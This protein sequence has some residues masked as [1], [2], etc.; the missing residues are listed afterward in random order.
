MTGNVVLKQ[1]ISVSKSV[2]KDLQDTMLIAK[3]QGLVDKAGEL[4]VD[5]AG[6]GITLELIEAAQEWVNRY[7]TAVPQPKAWINTRKQKTAAM[8]AVFEEGDEAVRVIDALA[9]IVEY[10]VPLFY[11]DY[12]S[13]RKIVNTA[14]RTRA[15][16]LW[17]RDAA[18]G[19]PIVKAMVLLR[20]IDG[21]VVG[22]NVKKTGKT[23]SVIV[24]HA[25][26]GECTYEVVMNG[27]VTESGRFFIVHGKMTKVE[28]VMRA[29]KNAV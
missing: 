21:D 6:Y 16:Q 12:R 23:G 10:T 29:V 8:A 5:A 14:R 28:V 15:L 11:M 13:A 9:R 18:R 22:K 25:E 26:E 4:L 19:K 1:R 2:L 3:A 27:F 7:T 24:K 17:V 20:T